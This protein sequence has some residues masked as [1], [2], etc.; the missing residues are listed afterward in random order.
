ML[1]AIDAL[2]H[3]AFSAK[4]QKRKRQKFVEF[5]LPALNNATLKII[6]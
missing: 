5:D 4:I 3:Q 6:H 1:E 2:E